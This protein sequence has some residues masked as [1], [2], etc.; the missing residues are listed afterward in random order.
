MPKQMPG[1]DVPDL[2]QVE[3]MLRQVLR[4]VLREE[5]ESIRGLQ[6]DLA[7]MRAEQ[8]RQGEILSHQGKT[9][10]EIERRLFKGNGRPPVT[11]ELIELRNE[12]KDIRRTLKPSKAQK[13]PKLKE[14]PTAAWA[15]LVTLIAAITGV[16]QAVAGYIQN[17]NP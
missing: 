14:I 12:I 15:A 17:L 5:S 8:V 11:T 2:G 13:A 1:H 10:T 3:N 16:V 4:Q 6:K 7:G 9:I